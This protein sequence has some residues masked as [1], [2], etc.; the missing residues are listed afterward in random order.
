[1]GARSCGRSASRENRR[2]GLELPTRYRRHSDT[3]CFARRS[4]A[5]SFMLSIT[6]EM[7]RS[8]EKERKKRMLGT[9]PETA[10]VILGE[11]LA[12]SGEWYRVRASYQI[13]SP[14]NVLTADAKTFE[15]SFR[16]SFAYCGRGMKEDLDGAAESVLLSSKRR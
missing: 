10:R 7:E 5:V 15:A 14:Q 9:I 4:A 16:V 11:Y 13:E 12:K 1:M 3:W 8:L 2:F 6:E